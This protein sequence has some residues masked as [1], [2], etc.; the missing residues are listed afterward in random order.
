[1]SPLSTSTKFHEN[2]TVFYTFAWKRHLIQK[3]TIRCRCLRRIF[4]PGRFTLPKEY[5]LIISKHLH[6]R[7]W[8]FQT[9]LI[10]TLD[11]LYIVVRD[12]FSAETDGFF[13]RTILFHLQTNSL[14]TWGKVW[15]S[16][17]IPDLY[18]DGTDKRNLD[19]GSSSCVLCE[20]NLNFVA[21]AIWGVVNDGSPA[22]L[23]SFIN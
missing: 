5:R 7:W 6:W 13:W 11:F 2:L 12:R 19:L 8:Q 3:F 23:Q 21:S 4:L 17:Y 9:K 15:K 18:R 16:P 1:M 14:R 10:V 22:G 20:N